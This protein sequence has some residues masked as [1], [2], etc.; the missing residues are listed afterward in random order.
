MSNEPDLNSKLV[1]NRDCGG[2]IVCCKELTINEPDIKKPPGILC[3]HCSLEDGGCGIY[4]TRPSICRNWFCGWRML[5]QL[6]ETWRPDK[7][8]IIVILSYDGIPEKY[9]QKA[10]LE[11]TLIGSPEKIH[12]QPLVEYI[13]GLVSTE[14][15]VFIAVTGKPGHASSKVLV[16][17]GV[18]SALETCDFSKIGDYLASA[19]EVC[20]K[21]AAEKVALE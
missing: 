3:K 11:F 5:P 15:P 13:T 17:D 14:V 1:P 12:W 7:S 2:C 20:V 6:D 21:H 18:L 9:Q 8:E 16:N 10:G 4:E 19:L